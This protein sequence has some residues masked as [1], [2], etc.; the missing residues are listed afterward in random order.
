MRKQLDIEAILEAVVATTAMLHTH[1][2]PH[3]DRVQ[4]AILCDIA[5]SLRRIAYIMEQDDKQ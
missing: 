2:Q 3:G 5:Q 1:L 4:I